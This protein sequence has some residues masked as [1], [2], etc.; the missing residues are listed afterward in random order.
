MYCT[1]LYSTVLCSTVLSSTV[2]YLLNYTQIDCTVLY[3]TKL[4]SLTHRIPHPDD[5]FKMVEGLN[6]NVY[7]K[8]G[9]IHQ[10]SS[11][12]LY[13]WHMIVIPLYFFTFLEKTIWNEHHINH[14]DHYFYFG[15]FVELLKERDIHKV[16]TCWKVQQTVREKYNKISILGVKQGTH[17]Y[18]EIAQI[19]FHYAQL[20][21]QNQVSMT[22]SYHLMSC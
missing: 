19:S 5:Y 15:L 20:T 3:C 1:L 16:P 9:Y 2:L 6:Y 13:D 8:R 21:N 12:Y 10:E 22:T 18:S 14:V 4:S 17:L 7:T 11:I